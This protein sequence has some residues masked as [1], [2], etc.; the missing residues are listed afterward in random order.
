MQLPGTPTT[1][2]PWEFPVVAACTFPGTCLVIHCDIVTL[3]SAAQRAWDASL[4]NPERS[5]LNSG[6][7]TISTVTYPQ[8]TTD[9]DT[10][11]II[12]NY[13]TGGS[14]GGSQYIATYD[15]TTGLWD[16]PHEFING[17]NSIFY[18]DDYGTS[19]N[20]RNAY[21]N[22]LDIDTTGRLHTTWTWRETA[23][24]SS[25]H[26]IMYAY[27]DDGGD[28]WRNEMLVLWSAQSATRST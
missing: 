28:T 4:F 15:A 14:G 10:G 13:R 25:N 27:S 21:L 5:A 20:N 2:Y 1:S 12:I 17:T 3:A 11:D 8:F 16:T 18:D 19:S 22:G 23:T 24:G 7:S 9:Q 26:D 6:G